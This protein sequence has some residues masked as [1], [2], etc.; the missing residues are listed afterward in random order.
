MLIRCIKFFAE[1][2]QHFTK[3]ETSI[4]LFKALKVAGS[5][6]EFNESEQSLN[7]ISSVQIL[8]PRFKSSFILSFE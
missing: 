6:T 3:R 7:Y 4:I 5:E 8:N 2:Y 1:N